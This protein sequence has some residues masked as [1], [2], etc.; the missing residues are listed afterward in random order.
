M[1]V[2]DDDNVSDN[3]KYDTICFS[4][5]PYV[6]C[7]RA[8]APFPPSSR[9]SSATSLQPVLRDSGTSQDDKND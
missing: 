6:N 3:S 4:S 1:F 5:F 7:V 2:T 8:P 9:Y